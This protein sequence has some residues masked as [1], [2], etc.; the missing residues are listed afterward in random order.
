LLNASRREKLERL[1]QATDALLDP[2]RIFKNSILRFNDKS[3]E[4]KGRSIHSSDYFL[5]APTG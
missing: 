5:I 4:G 3:A 1:A 2:F